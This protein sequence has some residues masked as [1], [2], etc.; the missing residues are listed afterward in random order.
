MSCPAIIHLS[1]L[2][3]SL[4]IMGDIV[5]CHPFIASFV[6]DGFIIVVVFGIACYDVPKTMLGSEIIQCI[7]WNRKLLT[8][9]GVNLGGSQCSTELCL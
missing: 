7:L 2:P 9:R 6:V 3:R 5:I 4:L 8:K 1:L